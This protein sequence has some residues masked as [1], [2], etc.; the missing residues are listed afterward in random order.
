MYYKTLS[1]MKLF[2][3]AKKYI[4]KL[5]LSDSV[6][7]AFRP[8]KWILDGPKNQKASSEHIGNHLK[9]TDTSWYEKVSPLSTAG[10][11]IAIGSTLAFVKSLLDSNDTGKKVSALT[12]LMGM[13][14]M[15]YDNLKHG[16]VI[17]GEEDKSTNNQ[18]DGVEQQKSE[19]SKARVLKPEEPL[20]AEQSQSSE[21]TVEQK[22]ESEPK[23]LNSE[24]LKLLLKTCPNEVD[25]FLRELANS[26]NLENIVSLVSSTQDNDVVLGAIKVLGFSE[27]SVAANKLEEFVDDP[28]NK[29]HL[30]IAAASAMS[31]NLTASGYGT[32]LRLSEYGQDPQLKSACKK[33]ADSGLENLKERFLGGTAP[34]DEL[35]EITRKSNERVVFFL[36]RCLDSKN[37]LSARQEALSGLMDLGKGRVL[38]YDLSEYLNQNDPFCLDAINFYAKYEHGFNDVE[39]ALYIEDDSASEFSTD[40]GV[41]GAVSERNEELRCAAVKA[42]I[43]IDKRKALSS[44]LKYLKDSPQGSESR[45]IAN[46]F[47]AKSKHDLLEELVREIMDEDLSGELV[48]SAIDVLEENVDQRLKDRITEMIGSQYSSRNAIYLAGKLNIKEAIPAIEENLR[49]FDDRTRI[50]AVKALVELDSRSSKE[51]I[52]RAMNN[53]KN[54]RVREAQSAALYAI[55]T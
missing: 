16:F 3:C 53:E 37:S 38:L 44:L 20:S 51:K 19:A 22:G 4:R 47:L 49:S 12:T 2:I 5:K 31:S 43:K 36:H 29:L 55:A 21:P 13:G 9:S 18:F 45:K 8:W 41:P 30:R 54:N 46:E 52:S 34:V 14:V 7:W 27:S 32:L 1:L 24:E 11:V 42:L 50:N 28:A 17:S 6:M 35:V 33:Y 48:D 39:K 25:S 10:G 23:P 40:H 15:A 26:N